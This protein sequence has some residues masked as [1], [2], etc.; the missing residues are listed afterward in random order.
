MALSRL[1]LL[2]AAASFLAAASR[3]DNVGVAANGEFDASTF[4]AGPKKKGKGGTGGRRRSAGGGG[5]EDPSSPSSSSLLSAVGESVSHPSPLLGPGHVLQFP[6]DT[7]P[8]AFNLAPSR[9]AVLVTDGAIHPGPPVSGWLASL[10]SKPR[11]VPYGYIVGALRGDAQKVMQFTD[12]QVLPFGVAEG[13]V[14]GDAP[15][16]PGGGGGGGGAPVGRVAVTFYQGPGLEVWYSDQGDLDMKLTFHE[17][18]IKPAHPVFDS[19]GKLWVPFTI[20]DRLAEEGEGIA[21]LW[22]Y[23][24]NGDRW[25][26]FPRRSFDRVRFPH[27]VRFDA[28][29]RLYAAGITKWLWDD[30]TYGQVFKPTVNSDAYNARLDVYEVTRDG[31]NPSFE[32]EQRIRYCEHNSCPD[33]AGKPP[34]HANWRAHHLQAA[35]HPLRSYPFPK[36]FNNCLWPLFAL[37]GDGHAIC[38]C[39]ESDT[40]VVM[41]IG[42]SGERGGD[43][44]EGEGEGLGEQGTANTLGLSEAWPVRGDAAEFDLVSDRVAVPPGEP[45]GGDGDDETAV[46][47]R[48]VLYTLR[49]PY[50]IGLI[51]GLQMDPSGAGFAIL[52]LGGK[53]V[54]GAPWPWPM[55]EDGTTPS[56]NPPR[57][58][59]VDVKIQR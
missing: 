55:E 31:G 54:V 51:G 41:R 24:P 58:R 2:A 18:A 49:Q 15:A 23:A 57:G 7:K 25:E 40:V 3:A 59:V 38:S 37:T 9:G 46:S 22:A 30:G 52:D 56:S 53:R 28:H 35:L 43:G 16:A 45:E 21:A 34:P 5:S 10:F 17:Y 12:R 42:A 48:L 27:T 8:R 13:P 11:P 4:G 20:A 32:K 14:P 47:E 19:T 29:G 36:P 50:G 26:T 44:G 1:L 39:Y 33:G 6:P